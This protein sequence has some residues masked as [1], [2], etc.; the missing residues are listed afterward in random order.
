MIVVGQGVFPVLGEGGTSDAAAVPAEAASDLRLEESRGRLITVGVRPGLDAAGVVDRHTDLPI[1]LPE[2]PAQIQNLR[3]VS[4]AP[5]LL[6]GF[7][8]ALGTAAVGHALVLS[9]RAGRRDLAVLKALGFARRQVHATVRWQASA[10]VA[11]GLI[12]GVPLGI[13]LGRWIWRLVV[14]S[15]GALVEPVMAP[16]LLAAA[17]A[18]AFLLANLIAAIPARAAGRTH[19]AHTLRT[20]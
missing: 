2:P 13:A 16:S 1:L 11:V 20:E 6:A 15:T 10:M 4:S 7:L 17:V 14:R 8:A 5:W 19:A 18:S 3:L 9:V 12:P